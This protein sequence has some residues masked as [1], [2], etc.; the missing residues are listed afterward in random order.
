MAQFTGDAVFLA[1]LSLIS[2]GLMAIHFGRQQKAK[3]VSAAGIVLAGGATLTAVCTSYY[4]L[5]YAQQGDFNHA[6]IVA[7]MDSTADER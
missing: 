3:L 2:F 4:W 5:S 7:R 6:Q 1:E